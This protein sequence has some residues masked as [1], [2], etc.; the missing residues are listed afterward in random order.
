MTRFR[1]LWAWT[2]LACCAVSV[3]YAARVG[4]DNRLELWLSSSSKASQDYAHF[5]ETFGSDEFVVIAYSGQSLFSEESLD[6]QLGVLESLEQVPNVAQVLSIPGVYR[7]R[8]GAED[9]EALAEEIQSQPAYR[10]LVYETSPEV[11]GF[12]VETKS[13]ATPA[14]RGELLAAL[15]SAVAPLESFGFQVH[16]VGPPQLNVALDETSR[17]EAA[18]TFPVAFGASILVL[19][20]LFRDL[21]ATIANSASAGLAILLTFGLMGMHH[22]SMNMITSALPT[23]LWVLSLAGSIHITRRYQEHRATGLPLDD[24]LR[25]ALSET[26]MPCTIAS[27]TTALGFL[28]LLTANM[29]PVR[30]LGIYAAAGILFSLAANLTILPLLLRLTNAPGLP[31]R[32][33]DNAT[34]AHRWSHRAMRWRY[35]SIVVAVVVLVVGCFSVTQIRFE[36]DPLTFLPKDDPV[37]EAYA[38]VGENLSGFYTLEI[39][40]DAPGGWLDPT[41]LTKVDSLSKSLASINGVARVL[42]PLDILLLARSWSDGTNDLPESAAVAESLI[43]SMDEAGQRQLRQLVSEDGRQIRL[44]LFVNVM[45]STPFLR[46]QDEVATQLATLPQAWSPHATGIVPQLVD[47][48]LS[49]VETQLNSFGLSFLLVF[50]CIWIGLRSFRAMLISIIPNVLPILVGGTVMAWL[51]IPLDAATVMAASV[52]MGI[53]V[54]DTV[55]LLATYRAR[56]ALNESPQERVQHVLE[57]LAPAM[58]ITTVVACIGFFALMRSA[59]LPIACFGLLSGITMAVAP[60]ADF[61]LLPALLGFWKRTK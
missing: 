18:R 20:L 27:V 10:R 24:A 35:G 55:H 41:F 32:R 22:G 34:W 13:L 57:H 19:L 46:L 23:L 9:A 38:F 3:P 12:V 6:A 14:G 49:L 59:F 11:G 25:M 50:A 53:A 61:F 39:M 15:R 47:A 16:M 7:D 44:S 29:M 4:I 40:L 8:F 45:S 31:V 30:E 51:D 54:D 33:H 5:R 2:L 36:S 60:W 43:A 42:S 21:R 48:Q 1:T 26:A 17:R 58:F 28:A 56:Q 52:A 37:A